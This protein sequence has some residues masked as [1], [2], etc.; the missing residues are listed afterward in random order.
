MGLRKR[1]QIETGLIED[2]WSWFAAE[3]KTL[4]GLLDAA[5]PEML[6]ETLDPRI[7]RL[8][9]DL[10]WEVGPGKKSPH[11]LTITS[12]GNRS[13]RAETDRIVTVAP[14]LPGWEF[15]PARQPTEMPKEVKLHD[16]NITV[17]TDHWKFSPR[18]DLDSG[19]IDIIIADEHLA[20]ADKN[21]AFAAVFLV[22][23]ALLGEDPVEGWIGKIT[24]VPPG[25]EYSRL[26]PI[27]ELPH[28][29]AWATTSPEGPL[30]TVS[31]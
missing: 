25:T 24:F 21:S 23:D 30:S 7:A 20:M 18:D 3:A 19:K 31:R 4:A 15:Y 6:A 16:K 29:I 11:S 22:L 28:Y 5:K 27:Q 9:Q 14:D 12:A 2:F 8:H 17:P 26:Y 10:A 13:L 1:Q